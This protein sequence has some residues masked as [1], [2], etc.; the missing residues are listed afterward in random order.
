MGQRGRTKEH[1]LPSD[2]LVWPYVNKNGPRVE[3]VE[4]NCWIWCGLRTHGAHF[5]R[6][7]G[8]GIIQ[9]RG[10]AN[11]AKFAVMM[12]HRVTWEIANGPIP[13]GML[14]CHRCDVRLCVRPDHLFLG[15]DKENCDDM[16]RKDR[17][18][19]AC[20]ERQHLAK[21]TE[22]AVRVIR[23]ERNQNP[24]TP[25][26]E[27]A[28]RFQTSLVAVS[29]AATGKTWKHLVGAPPSKPRKRVLHQ[30]HPAPS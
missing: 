27:L 8:Y 18:V 22:E 1:W 10:D 6:S 5:G 30:Q 9:P 14:V 7:G 25:L 20:G 12:A 29:Y 21:L 11:R 17:A 19:K 23:A 3:Y 24:P 4:T 28:E 16:Y 2:D 26:K 15:T 13:P